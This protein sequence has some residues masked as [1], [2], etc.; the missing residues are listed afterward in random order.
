MVYMQEK[1]KKMTTKNCHEEEERRRRRGIKRLRSESFQSQFFPSGSDACTMDD[2][3]IDR[4]RTGLFQDQGGDLMWN[5]GIGGAF[6]KYL[7]DFFVQQPGSQRA[8]HSVGAL[9]GL[10]GLVL[11]FTLLSSLSCFPIRFVASIRNSGSVSRRRI[12]DT[13]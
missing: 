10:F 11:Y 4:P 1:R 7:I 9:V 2:R 12:D 8:G 5:S 13:R 6:D 3:P